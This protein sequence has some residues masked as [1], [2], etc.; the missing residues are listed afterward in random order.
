MAT[1]RFYDVLRDMPPQSTIT[2]P[3]PP[4]PQATDYGG[5]PTIIR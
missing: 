3:P 2:Y 1:A 5:P 4:P